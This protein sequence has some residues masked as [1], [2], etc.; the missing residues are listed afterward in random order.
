MFHFYRQY[1]RVYD[2][3]DPTNL[4]RLFELNEDVQALLRDNKLSVGH[5][6]VLLG[7][8]GPRQSSLAAAVVSRQYSVRQTE[9]L[10]RST[11][12]PKGKSTAKPK[13]SPVENELSTKLGLAVQLR[14]GAD[15]AGV[16]SIRFRQKSE[17]DKLVRLLR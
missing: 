3:T 9:E 4:L 2:V 11:L 12:A 5:A 10:V 16:L 15:G 1:L 8:G 7:V 17:L 13:R 6:K 14:H